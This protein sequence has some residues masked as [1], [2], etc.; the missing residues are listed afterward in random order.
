MYL[1]KFDISQDAVALNCFEKLTY[2]LCPNPFQKER[3][4]LM[5]SLKFTLSNLSLFLKGNLTEL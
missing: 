5:A 3:F 1:H 4:C 2:S